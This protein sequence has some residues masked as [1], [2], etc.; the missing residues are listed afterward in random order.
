M[1]WEL[2]D[3]ISPALPASECAKVYAAIG[4]GESY[5]AI[6]TMLCLLVRDALPLSTKLIAQLSGWLNAFDHSADA[7]RLHELL[8]LIESRL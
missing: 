6:T 3:A 4:S 1:A 8:S 7:R 5:S 2:V